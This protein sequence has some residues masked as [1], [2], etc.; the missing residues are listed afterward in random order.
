MSMTRASGDGGG[1]GGGSYGPPELQARLQISLPLSLSDLLWHLVGW[2]AER[3]QPA[4]CSSS[5]DASDICCRSP[6]GERE[7]RLSHKLKE[8]AANIRFQVP[9]AYQQT[10]ILQLPRRTRFALSPVWSHRANRA[11]I[12]HATPLPL[13]A[14]PSGNPR[15]PLQ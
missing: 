13:N 14:P 3:E 1:G 6:C 2:D 12:S 10:G 15:I 8:A 9:P 7:P 11:G 5:C 4:L